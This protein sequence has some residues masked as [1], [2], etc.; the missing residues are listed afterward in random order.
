MAERKRRKDEVG[1]TRKKK[2][3]PRDRRW[4]AMIIE[5]IDGRWQRRICTKKGK[6]KNKGLIL[7]GLR[8]CKVK[9]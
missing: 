6:K 2:S 5:I 9:V 7:A 8:R 4:N 1:E 3:E